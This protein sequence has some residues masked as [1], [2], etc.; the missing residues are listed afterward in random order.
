MHE[1]IILQLENLNT[2]LNVTANYLQRTIDNNLKS[3]AD[4]ETK[5]ESLI[6][7]LEVNQEKIESKTATD[8]TRE[9]M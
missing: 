3:I 1:Y 7:H 8:M 9:T 4:K 6:T 2:R 5:L